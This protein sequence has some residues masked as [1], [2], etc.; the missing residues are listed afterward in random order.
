MSSRASQWPCPQPPTTAST[1]WRRVQSTTACGHRRRTGPGRLRMK[2]YG[3]RS[4]K[5]PGMRCSSICLTKTPRGCGPGFERHTMEHIVDF[6]LLCAHGADSR[7]SCCAGGAAAARRAPV[8]RQAF[9]CSEAGY[10]SPKILPVGVPFRAEEQLVEVPTIV[11]NSSLQWIM[12]QNVDIPV[13]GRG[14][15]L[16]VFKVFFPD[17]VQQ[18]CM[19][20]RT[21]L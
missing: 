11:S 1:R 3:D 21:H 10:R 14:G 6:C 15:R 8:L 2:L 7:R 13:P 20:L 18:R 16:A 12:E 19:F 9:D 17:R 4:P 5:Q